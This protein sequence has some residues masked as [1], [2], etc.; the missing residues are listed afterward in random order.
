MEKFTL[1]RNNQKYFQPLS[2]MKSADCQTYSENDILNDS[3]VANTLPNSFIAKTLPNLLPNESNFSSNY[4]HQKNE[5]K[6]FIQTENVRLTMP[7]I[8]KC[9]DCNVNFKGINNFQDHINGVHLKIKTH[10][11]DDC[12]KSFT[13][14]GNLDNHIRKVHPIMRFSTEI[15]SGGRSKNLKGPLVIKDKVRKKVLLLSKIGGHIGTPINSS[16]DVPGEVANLFEDEQ[17]LLCDVDECLKFFLNENQKNL[18]KENNNTNENFEAKNF[19]DCILN[20][21][22]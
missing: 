4:N 20:K 18:T 17:D 22:I 2:K 11:C 15:M 8:L 10:E 13:Y 6:N 9:D 3:F 1:I 19:M 5:E 16:P 7:R 12:V 14:K 21:C